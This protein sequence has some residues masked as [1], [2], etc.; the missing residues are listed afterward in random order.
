VLLSDRR[1]ELM[2]ANQSI[3][4][5]AIADAKSK[6][7]SN[8]REEDW[9]IERTQ[10][11]QHHLQTAFKTIPNGQDGTRFADVLTCHS[12]ETNTCVFYFSGTS[13]CRMIH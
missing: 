8:I 12:P 3:T 1:K 7:K 6:N 11:W 5:K 9:K 4:A 2:D 13:I 10:A